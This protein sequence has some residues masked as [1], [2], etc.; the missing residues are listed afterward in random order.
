[1]FDVRLFEC[2]LPFFAIKQPPYNLSLILFSCI[3]HT[4]NVSWEK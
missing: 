1:M 3:N 4:K 2:S